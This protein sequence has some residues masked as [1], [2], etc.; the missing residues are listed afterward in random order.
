MGKTET[1][2]KTL[3]C[4]VCYE[5]DKE[6]GNVL[7]RIPDFIW[8]SDEYHVLVSDDASQDNT[9][10]A[11]VEKMAG[12]ASNV[13]IQRLNINQGYGGNQKACY[14]N[15][16]ENGFDG[17]VLLHGDGQYPPE[18]IGDMVNSMKKGSHVVLGSRMMIKRDALKGGMPFYKFIGNIVLTTFQNTMAGKRL[19]EFH[20]GFR[21]YRTD[22][23]RGVPFELNG[24]DFHFDTEILLQAFH[25]GANI[26]E[27]AIPTHYGDEICR[28][29]GFKYGW[30]VIKASYLYR[31]QRLGLYVS[32]QYPRSANLVYKDKS[33]DPNSTHAVTL[34]YI[35]NDSAID[36]VLDIGCGPGYVARQIHRQ[37]I[38]V[39]GV[40]LYA[41]QETEIFEDFYIRDL[42]D[43]K[44]EWPTES[45]SYD[46]ILMLDVL[47]HLNDPENFLL[48]LRHSLQQERKPKILVS[49]PNVAFILMRLNLLAGRFNYADRGILDISHR[50]F[51]TKSTLEKLFK[52]TG[53]E[54]VSIHGI[55]VPFKS[56]ADNFLFSFAGKL[57][58]FLAKI[59]PSLFAFQFHC[60]VSV[61][62]TT[63]QILTKATVYEEKANNNAG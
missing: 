36:S 43:L 47:E 50:R 9:A 31:L 35:K 52:E 23:L 2:F 6:I 15:A 16:V 53:Y 58:S 60:E 61:K 27:I 21:A 28:V 18:M 59:W 55:G 45:K 39:T 63:K 17:V 3:I 29:D 19:H 62:Q 49:V 4:L 38:P 26:E 56:L 5:A 7:E 34:D 48:M 40:D 13:T 10:R 51:F 30:D 37:G 11:A 44:S 46:L 57:S 54:V 1:S 25:F 20:T 32:L 14:L 12:R 41:P 33:P 22:F 24:D 42:N 8:N